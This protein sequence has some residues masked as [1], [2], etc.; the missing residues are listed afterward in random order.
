MSSNK[1]DI[2]SGAILA[3][4]AIEGFE[5]L[6]MLVCMWADPEQ[7]PEVKAQLKENHKVL[8]ANF[9]K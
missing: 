6:K 8:M 9:T 1:K 4:A 7:L 3:A 2:V 5:A